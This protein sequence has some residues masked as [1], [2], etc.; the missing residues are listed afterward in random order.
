MAKLT[1]QDVLDIR[2]SYESGDV[3]SILAARYQV[4]QTLISAIV[5]RKNWAQVH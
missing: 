1:E 5:R 3:Q 2:N 4:S